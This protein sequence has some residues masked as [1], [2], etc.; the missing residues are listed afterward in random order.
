MRRWGKLVIG[1]L[2]IAFAIVLLAFFLPHAL[3][4]GWRDTARK[5]EAVPF[6]DV[7]CLTVVWAAGLW[8]HA[9]V[10]RRSLPGLSRRHAFALNLGG[11]SV[12]NILPFGGAAGIG[13]NYAMLRS[14]GYD[15]VQITA[16]AT[17]SNL[18]VVLVKIVIAVAGIVALSLMPDIASQLSQPTSSGA[19]AVYIGVGVVLVG[20]ICAYFTW[21]R[22]G[23]AV[24]SD[25]G[26]R[27]SGPRLRTCCAAAGAAWRSAVWDTPCCRLC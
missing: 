25:T 15:R 1:L 20:G 24:V 27:N 23:S 3:G 22:D 4:I 2:S 8:L 6:F 10:L 17:V 14:W 21:A 12:S 11:S 5:I 18:V 9:I 26:S 7:I 16:F 13:L 19:I